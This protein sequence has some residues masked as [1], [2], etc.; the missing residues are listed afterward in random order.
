MRYLNL[1]SVVGLHDQVKGTRVIRSSLILI[2]SGHNSHTAKLVIL[3][4]A[5][6]SLLSMSEARLE[7]S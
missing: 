5:S 1:S 4:D 2:L 6:R 3:N 7:V